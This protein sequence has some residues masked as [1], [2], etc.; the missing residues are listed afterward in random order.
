MKIIAI[1]L[2]LT[3]LLLPA[4]SMATQINTAVSFYPIYLFTQNV[5]NG[6]EGFEL[7]ML[8]PP[9]GGCLHDYQ[10]LTGDMRMLAESD[11]L[12]ING[13]GM[14]DG[15]LPQI[16]RQL[17]NLTVIDLS[18]GIDVIEDEH[19]VNAHIWLDPKNAV[20]M[21]HNI[22]DACV[23]LSPENEALIRANEQ[24]YTEKLIALDQTLAESLQ[25][26][27]NKNIATFHEAFPY[28]AKA[29]GLNA[30]ASVTLDP[31][32]APSPRELIEVIDKIATAS[33][34]PLF[35]EP[36][37]DSDALKTVAQETGEKVYTL[38]PVTSGDGA[39]DEYE[40][41]MLGNLETLLQALNP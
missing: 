31:D 30:V 13:A 37:V 10:L 12:L 15:F 21:V 3:L 17:P 8:T 25:S 9:N 34:C 2:V 33:P 16:M 6:V 14:E 4:A 38:D 35:S 1:L 41:K 39:L 20:I 5:L 11:V 7:S 18:V 26:T 40:T 24:T 28:F 32:E 36:G 23:S 19:G 27:Q 29:Y 22:A